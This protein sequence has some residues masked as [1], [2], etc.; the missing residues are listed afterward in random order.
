MLHTPVQTAL[1]HEDL[2]HFLC[3]TKLKSV[4]RIYQSHMYEVTYMKKK[5]QQAQ[6]RVLAT[7]INH[8]WPRGLTSCCVLLLACL[9]KRLVSFDFALVQLLR[10]IHGEP[11]MEDR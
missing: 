5:R 3:R 7:V 2:L 6:I 9:R 1:I 8:A 11:K 4:L 10:E